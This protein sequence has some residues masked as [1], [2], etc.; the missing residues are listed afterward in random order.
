MEILT[1]N[2]EEGTAI[3]KQG[4]N[5]HKT[6]ITPEIQELIDK[7]TKKQ[8]TKTKQKNNKTNKK[9]NTKNKT[10][11]HTPKHNKQCTKTHQ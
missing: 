2:L 7:H 5:I 4:I 8:E 3:I 1:Y 9:L 6:H 10:P 11:T